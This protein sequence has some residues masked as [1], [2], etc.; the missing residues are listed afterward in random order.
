MLVFVVLASL[1]N[2]AAGVLP[3]LYAIIARDLGIAEAALGWVTAVYLLVMAFSAIFWGYYGDQARRKPLLFYGTLLW[4]GAMIL[5]AFSQ[6]Y[7][8]FLFFQLLTAVGVGGIASIGF[9]VISDLCPAEQRGFYLSFWTI[10]QGVGG[11]LGAL[12]AGIMGANDWRLPFFF[13]AGLGILFAVLYLFTREPLRGQAEP[14]LQ[15]V[16]NTGHQYEYRIQPN[17]LWQLVQRPSMRWLLWQNFGFALSF[18]STAWIAR[19]VI[20]RIQEEGYG[21]DVATT[22]GNIFVALF[23][24]GAFTAVGSGYLGDQL[25]K[26]H[27]R[28]RALLAMGSL[29]AGIP[30]FLLLYFTPLDGLQL[31]PNGQI[32][33]TIWA[34]LLNLFSNRGVFIAFLAA[35]VAL[36]FQ[37]V[38]GANWTAM[39]TDA[40]LP[41]HRGTVM[42]L[43]RL[44][45]ALGSSLS[46][47]LASA[48][49][50]QF[51]VPTATQYAL[52]LAAF[53]LFVIPTALCYYRVSKTIEQDITA[54][55][56][57]L[58]SRAAQSPSSVADPI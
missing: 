43:S 44:T 19:W 33:S 37:S 32:L 41:E 6:T 55:R 51:P 7:W 35:F 18:G 28:Y 3:P 46:M 8:Q 1:D 17:E 11:S 54:V 5:T 20:A 34:V 26:R 42:G 57:T 52:V 36:I 40:N 23:S 25:Q 53:Q 15:A 22:A 56:Q 16:F 9:S 38:N 48:L 10:A 31:P 39:I 2:A 21:L 14:E 49:L 58:L 29:L 13:I 45:N 50:M 27:L 4:S 47:A 12:L 24:L 30:F